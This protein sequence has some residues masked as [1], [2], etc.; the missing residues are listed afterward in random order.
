MAAQSGSTLLPG[1]NEDPEVPHKPNGETGSSSNPLTWQHY[2]PYEDEEGR[3][4][5]KAGHPAVNKSLAQKV[6]QEKAAH[7]EQ[8]NLNK[9]TD[10]IAT[11]KKASLDQKAEEQS[12]PQRIRGFASKHKK[13]L[14]IGGIL[15]SGSIGAVIF[16]SSFLLPLK[17]DFMLSRLSS[18]FGATSQHAMSSM[19]DKLLN[20][21]VAKY[22][23]PGIKSG[24]CTSTL[25]ITC[26]G[27]IE[28]NNPVSY[29]YK[30]WKQNHIETKMAEKY[31]VVV[32]K[33]LTGKYG[34][35]GQ[36]YIAV[37]GKADITGDDILKIMNGDASIFDVG[38]GVNITEF[39]AE[40]R[41]AYK[42]ASLW[43]KVY[44]RFKFATLLKEKYGVRLCAFACKITDPL[45]ASAADLKLA[46]KAQIIDYIIA[47]MSERY[48]AI[49]ACVL[50]GTGTCGDTLNK[51]D[52]TG[53][54]AD[55]ELT[56]AQADLQANLRAY[57]ASMGEEDLASVVKD[58]EYLSKNGL[59]KLIMRKMLEPIF[60][61][62]V[63]DVI[64]GSSVVLLV[65]VIM[66]IAA[67]LDDVAS[68]IGPYLRHMDFSANSAAAVKMFMQY[69]TVDSEMKSGNVS[70][71]GLA[72]YSDALGTNLSG[73]SS[74]QA[75]FT[76]SP[77]YG[78]LFG[79]GVDPAKTPYK[80]N[81]GSSVPN[82]KLVCN[83]ENL[84]AGNAIADQISR[85]AQMN[86]ILG[87]PIYIQLWLVD[88]ASDLL[89]NVTGF[90]LN[91][92]WDLYCHAED[93][94]P[95]G[96]MC[97]KSVAAAEALGTNLFTRFADW[98][99]GFLVPSPFSENMSGGRTFDMI[100][101]G[102]DVASN[103]TCQVELGCAVQSNQ[104]VLATR[105]QELAA[106]KLDFQNQP[107]IARLFSTDTPYSLLS[108]A[109]MAM[110]TSLTDA[111]TSF[112]GML[113]NPFGLLASL[114]SNM[115]DSN[116]VF[117]ADMPISDP[118]GVIQYGYND[119][120][121]PDDPQTYWEQHC[122]G[123]FT[124]AFMSQETQDDSTGEGVN[125]TPQP[126]LLI[127]SMVQSS[128]TMFDSSLAPP[129]SQNPDPPSSQ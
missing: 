50:L 79:D 73:S 38:E 112:S 100:A 94:M 80:C 121:I 103:K 87:F 42:E 69:Q 75:D 90:F 109:A 95:P 24:K 115:F 25:E 19:G 67:K 32:G 93:L 49:F 88:H 128:G 120:Q 15:T 86:H 72:S 29:L 89:N 125:T 104:Q 33:D 56:D 99:M 2:N 77:L 40:I 37:N 16:G 85:Q 22:V 63:D 14:S 44:F 23:L 117:A 64:E 36:L 114:F 119:N 68:N 91:H 82:G 21:Y 127:Q 34:R 18:I 116:R 47:P 129:D 28:G 96:G 20:Q 61:D 101:A 74:D 84:T 8:K 17:I 126:C 46:A 54:T 118:F 122:Q 83:E 13:G 11:P 48:A 123:D 106:E 102:A 3:L 59:T 70:P 105:N 26:I 41:A 6:G 1:S 108:Q 78:A 55:T 81:D 107:L 7:S 58:S 4:Q 10:G 111:A 9:A 65:V 60:G 62:A 66:Q 92:A 45:L 71:A 76:T 35:P 57:T 110:P 53:G 124:T 12:V 5:D 39:R 43:D 97:S 52:N 113:S 98:V 30:A 51:P 31:G 27:P